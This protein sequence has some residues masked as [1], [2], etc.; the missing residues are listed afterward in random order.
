MTVRAVAAPEKKSSPEP[1]VK[2]RN[3]VEQAQ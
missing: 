3:V 2:T 1:N